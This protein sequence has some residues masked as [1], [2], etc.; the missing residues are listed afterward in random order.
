MN[1]NLIEDMKIEELLVEY[2]FAEAFFSENA[3][4]VTIKL[5]LNFWTN[6]LKKK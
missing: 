3:I 4:E 5:L 6:L 1:K 2:P